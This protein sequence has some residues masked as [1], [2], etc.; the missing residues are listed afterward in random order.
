[1]L[2]SKNENAEHKEKFSQVIVSSFSLACQLINQNFFHK[3]VIVLSEEKI[4]EKA[5]DS[6]MKSQREE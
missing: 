1:M 3:I 6:R 4:S 5:R 2:K